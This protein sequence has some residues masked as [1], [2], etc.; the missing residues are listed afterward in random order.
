M[1][2][3]L[4]M[5]ADRIDNSIVSLEERINAVFGDYKEG[6]WEDSM[7]LLRVAENANVSLWE[8]STAESIV[9]ILG[10]LVCRWEHDDD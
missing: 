4:D 1:P 5:Q 6:Y 2:S 8:R 9:S 7:R 3:Y 10:E